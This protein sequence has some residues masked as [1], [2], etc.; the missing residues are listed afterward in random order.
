MS[1]GACAG[2]GVG[3]RELAL[4]ATGIV[5]EDDGTPLPDAVSSR[6]AFPVHSSK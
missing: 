4:A 5:G 1:G 6:P 2:G 3:A